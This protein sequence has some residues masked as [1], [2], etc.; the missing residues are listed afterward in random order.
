M[1]QRDPNYYGHSSALH[2]S[3]MTSDNAALLQINS[4]HPKLIRK[5]KQNYQ[6]FLRRSFR[7]V[8]KSGVKHLIIDLRENVK[9]LGMKP[10]PADRRVESNRGAV[11][12]PPK[13]FAR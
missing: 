1:E 13:L 8:R 9:Q 7:D 10:T 4:F 12:S 11:A 6:R 5:G 2:Y 3:P